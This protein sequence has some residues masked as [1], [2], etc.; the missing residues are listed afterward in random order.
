MTAH[1][2]LIGKLPEGYIEAYLGLGS[3][4]GDR[5][6]QL[7]EAVYHLSS[8]PD[9]Q[10]LKIS[11][12]YESSPSNMPP[13][14]RDFLNAVVKITVAMP[15][16]DLLVTCMGIERMMGRDRTCIGKDRPIDLDILYIDGVNIRKPELILP[17]PRAHTRTFVL[18]PWI[19]IEPGFS[20]YGARLEEWLEMLP[21]EEY[22]QCELFGEIPEYQ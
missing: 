4:Q 7:S 10:A 6:V 8:T 20:L 16:E 1:F 3:N 18:I 15:P 17:H 11:S 14:T 13:G 22:V 9:I 19:E 12:A 2:E 21:V 5:L